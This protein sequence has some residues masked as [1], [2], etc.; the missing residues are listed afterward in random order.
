MVFTLHFSDLF[1]SSTKRMQPGKNSIILS[2]A[3]RFCATMGRIL[4]V[5]YHLPERIR[6]ADSANYPAIKDIPGAEP[7]E[8]TNEWQVYNRE[9]D[10]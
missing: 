5:I 1:R 4:G 9:S 8:L 2:T 3:T 10:C 7:K 6:D